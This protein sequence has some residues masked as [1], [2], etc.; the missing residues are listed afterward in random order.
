MIE[1]Y[2]SILNSAARVKAL[3]KTTGMGDKKMVRILVMALLL[4]SAQASA[5]S[6]TWVPLATAEKHGTLSD[7]NGNSVLEYRNAGRGG[8]DWQVTGTGPT[9][10]LGI[11]ELWL[12][13]NS[14]AGIPGTSE[15][16]TA[17]SV[18]SNSVGFVMA[19]D[20]NDGFAQFFVDNIDVGTFDM[21][22]TGDRVLMVSGLDLIAHS[23]R[24]VQLGQHNPS[25]TKGDV[26]IF[27]GAAFILPIATIPEPETYM[28]L[29]VGL[30]LLGFSVRYR[31]R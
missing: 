15:A 9:G 17:F 19:G 12:F 25:S 29:L 16:T 4:I 10:G 18:I 28:M 6:I 21:Y 2:A 7:I 5:L 23:L 24:V 26:A 13:D 11:R 1:G 3:I 14:A 30:G 31:R 20:H 8:L 27:G 22:Q